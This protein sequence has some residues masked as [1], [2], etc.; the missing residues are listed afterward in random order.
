MHPSPN[1]H[2]RR[3][4]GNVDMRNGFPYHPK[5]T[6]AS[7]I[8]QSMS[9]HTVRMERRKSLQVPHTHKVVLEF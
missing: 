3:K 5:C 7:P 4:K 2:H 9:D 1:P 8:R 6:A